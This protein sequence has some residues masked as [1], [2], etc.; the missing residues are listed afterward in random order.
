MEMEDPQL[1]IDRARIVMAAK[2]EL[3]QT[4]HSVRCSAA[5]LIE[6]IK[7]SESRGESP[8]EWLPG[9]KLW[10]AIDYARAATLEGSRDTHLPSFVRE[11]LILSEY[12]DIDIRL[13]AQNVN[14]HQVRRTPNFPDEFRRDGKTAANWIEIL[15]RGT[16]E[17]SALDVY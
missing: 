17:F 13:W 14:T 1:I 10:L 7:L 8:E 15:T 16:T 9:T 12:L 4:L 3:F 2:K 6:A 11:M 5:S